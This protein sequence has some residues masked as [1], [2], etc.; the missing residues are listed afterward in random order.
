MF[1]LADFG[2]IGLGFF[3]VTE[4]ELIDART[5]FYMGREP[6][7]IDVHTTI[8]GLTFADAWRGR[9]SAHSFGVRTEVLAELIAANEPHSRCAS[10][11]R[12]RLSRTPPTSPGSKRS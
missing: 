2:D 5:G 6:D 4:A 9:I 7:R 1:A 11:T 10:L 8:A 12:P 3:E